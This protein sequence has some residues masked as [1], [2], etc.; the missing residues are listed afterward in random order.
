MNQ[1]YV[2]EYNDQGIVSNPIRGKYEN[3]SPNRKA[4]RSHKNEPR[5]VNNRNGHK[6]VIG[7]NFK[8]R[9]KIQ[10]EFDKDGKR[11]NVEHYVLVK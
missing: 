3:L 1:P 9:K 4:R 7:P 8:Y 11:K 6:L 2:K 5:F 10:V